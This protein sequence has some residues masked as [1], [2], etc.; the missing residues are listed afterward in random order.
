MRQ[1]VGY[2]LNWVLGIFNFRSFE[3]NNSAE[4]EAESVEIAGAT[5][6]AIW[7]VLLE[8]SRRQSGFVYLVQKSSTKWK[9]TRRIHRDDTF[10]ILIFVR[11]SRQS[12]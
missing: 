7:N 10:F 4:P 9:R 12:I 8:E 6:A 2:Y 11:D 5:K 1:E 3:K